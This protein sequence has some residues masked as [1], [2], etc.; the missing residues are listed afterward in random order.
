MFLPFFWS[1]GSDSEYEVDAAHQKTHSF[2]N[3]Y[4][5]D[6]TYYNSWRRQQ[7]GVSRPPAYSYGQAEGAAEPESRPHA[8]PLP[9]LPPLLPHSTPSPQP[10]GQGTLF[11]PKGSRTPTP[12]LLSSEIHNQHGLY[13][14]PSSLGSSTQT[15]TTGFSSF[16]WYE[17]LV[18][19]TTHLIGTPMWAAVCSFSIT[20]I[21][22]RYSFDLLKSVDHLTFNF[23]FLFWGLFFVCVICVCKSIE[24][25]RQSFS[26]F[27]FVV[28]AV[29]ASP[30]A[31]HSLTMHN[32]RNS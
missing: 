14:P 12:S 16:V 27:V 32:L 1:Q 20:I 4:I 15:P 26:T 24:K 3:H 18:P 30:V 8:P 29:W 17:T 5:S 2:V 31:G 23:L 7:K 28:W 22:V 11:R 21:V 25:K 10:M 19:F 6:P 13:R 9:P